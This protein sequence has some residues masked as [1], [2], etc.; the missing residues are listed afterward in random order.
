MIQDMVFVKVRNA[1]RPTYKVIHPF[2]VV[3]LYK[4]VYTGCLKKCGPFLNWY[5]SFIYQE[6][7]PKF[8]MVV[9]K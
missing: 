8:C 1:S 4:S 6:I 9:A 2:Y 5:N 3:I 7:F